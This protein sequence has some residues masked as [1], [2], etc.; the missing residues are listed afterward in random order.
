MEECYF[1]HLAGL[2]S[3]CKITA[4]CSIVIWGIRKFFP[5]QD[6]PFYNLQIVMTKSS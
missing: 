1:Y 3:L 6:Y 2:A 4:V 5:I